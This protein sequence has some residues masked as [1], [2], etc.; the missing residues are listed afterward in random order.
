MCTIS[1]N[2][3]SLAAVPIGTIDGTV[4]SIS[5]TVTNCT[6]NHIS[7]TVACAGKAPGSADAVISGNT[8][9][10]SVYNKCICGTPVAI[11]ATCQDSV[12]C[13]ATYNTVLSCSCCPQVSTVSNQGLYNSAG[14]RLVTFV[15]T[16]TFPAGCSGTV[17]RDF[18]DG[19]LG[20]QHT[21]ISSPDSYQETHAYNTG[22]TYTSN[23]NV[24]S[25]ASCGPSSDSV[26]V[27][28]AAPPCATSSFW[29][30]VCRL[31]QF[32]FLWFG[33]AAGV[34]SIASA[35]PV[36][37]PPYTFPLFVIAAG[38]AITATV[39]LV[40]LYLICRKCVCGFTVKLLGQLLLIMGVVLFMFVLPANCTQS[41]PFSTPVMAL[42][43]AMLLLLGG[44]VALLYV[45]WYQQLSNNCPL[46]IC[47]YWRAISDALIVAIF[48]ALLVFASMSTGLTVIHLGIA[49]LAISLLLI[50]SNQQIQNNQ[51]AGNC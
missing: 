31:L 16:L 21:F 24:L 5:G 10:A 43:L 23:L 41:V 18:G 2:S 45:L 39:F 15:T 40:V 33:A 17:Q 32:M 37:N 48:V 22:L 11:T 6:S 13:T 27:S 28:T 30:A 1:I 20:A 44:G 14:Q 26:V 38:C 36:C 50:M 25:N 29:A 49:L 42:A 8:W 46:N 47:D 12:P 35:S 4:V 34:L 7:V 51:N 19:N 3:A 9:T